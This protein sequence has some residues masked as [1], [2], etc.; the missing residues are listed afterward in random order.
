[1]LTLWLYGGN[2]LDFKQQIVRVATVVLVFKFLAFNCSN[3]FQ[4]CKTLWGPMII[5]LTFPAITSFGFT[6]LQLVQQTFFTPSTFALCFGF[7]LLRFE[8]SFDSLVITCTCFLRRCEFLTLCYLISSLLS[9]FIAFSVFL[10][11]HWLG[12]SWYSFILESRSW[13]SFILESRIYRHKL[14]K[15]I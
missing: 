15:L 5:F 6:F 13:Y 12:T 4:F 1:M 3:I 11:I 9:F 8:P 2:V 7:V 14:I 10:L